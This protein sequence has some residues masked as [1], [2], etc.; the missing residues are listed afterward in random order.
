M[1]IGVVGVEAQRFAEQA[2]RFDHPRF[3]VRDRLAEQRDRTQIAVVCVAAVGRDA[4]ELAALAQRERG[5]ERFG[6]LARDRALEVEDVREITV[7]VRGQQMTIVTDVDQLHGEAQR[8]AFAPDRAFEDRSDAQPLADLPDIGRLAAVLRYRGAR[9]HLEVAQA[10]QRVED[11]LLQSV[12]EIGVF[13]AAAQVL[14]RK[15]RD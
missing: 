2:L 12:R 10:R 7:V 13:G 4:V 15:H 5:G 3:V 9:Y 8:V 14:E 1:R 6:D 11:L